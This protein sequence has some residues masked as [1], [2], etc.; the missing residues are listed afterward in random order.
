MPDR[1]FTSTLIKQNKKE[2]VILLLLAGVIAYTFSGSQE[3]TTTTRSVQYSQ[4]ITLNHIKIQDFEK[5]KKR[6]SLIGE[7]TYILENELRISLENVSIVVY[8]PEVNDKIEFTVTAQRGEINWKNGTIV[9]EQDV[10]AL[11]E[12]DLQ[13]SADKIIYFYD[14]KILQIPQKVEIK[15]GT[16]Y[17]TGQNL[18]YHIDTKSFKLNQANLSL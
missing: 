17:L 12:P 14:K 11:Q 6:W 3:I 18:I 9:L 1:H 5:D 13:L 16:D 4:A 15:R 2:V 7:K 10:V 8:D